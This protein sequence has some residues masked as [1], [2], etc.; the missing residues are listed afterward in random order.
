[1]K[2]NLDLQIE[3]TNSLY[4]FCLSTRKMKNKPELAAIAAEREIQFKTELEELEKQKAATEQP[5][6][7]E[8]ERA[9]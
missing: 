7:L 3:M 4:R 6:L 8:T 2:S 1:M 9:A 5:E